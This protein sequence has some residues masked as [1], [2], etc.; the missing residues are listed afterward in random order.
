MSLHPTD[1]ELKAFVKS[2]KPG[3]TVAIYANPHAGAGGGERWS[4]S[5]VDRITPKGAFRIR[6]VGGDGVE[7]FDSDGWRRR[8]GSWG[9]QEILVPWSEDVIKHLAR[10]KLVH[11]VLFYLDRS[12]VDRE[13]VEKMADDD[14]KRL[15]MALRPL[16]K[17]DT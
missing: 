11:S 8:G 17:K 14:L 7:N 16:R 1:A 3:D 5:V 12:V 2:L 10:E 4:K 13:T 9:W 15:V 6:V